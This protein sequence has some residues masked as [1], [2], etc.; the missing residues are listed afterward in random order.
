VISAASF[1]INSL[2][3]SLQNSFPFGY[4]CD[5][6]MKGRNRRSLFFPPNLYMGASVYPNI[7]ID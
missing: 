7:E 5:G 2:W 3:H 1:M 6:E 4:V